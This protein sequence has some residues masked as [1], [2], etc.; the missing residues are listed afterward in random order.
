VVEGPHQGRP[1]RLVSGGACRACGGRGGQC[2][3]G[4][5]STR[6]VDAALKSAKPGGG[7]QRAASESAREPAAPAKGAKD[8]AAAA[9]V[10]PAD[11]AALYFRAKWGWKPRAE[12]E[13]AFEK[14]Q[15][16]RVSQKK[17]EWWKGRTTDGVSGWFP[18]DRVRPVTDAVAHP[19]A[20]G[21]VQG[22]GV[23]APHH[24]AQQVD[25]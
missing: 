12:G 21:D 8:G 16:I 1:A 10:V 7:L 6:A 14:G 24:D 15:E 17:D 2:R 11:D 22:A 3:A 9:V 5:R 19:D 13:L 18:K 20:R 4:R 23:G 25:S